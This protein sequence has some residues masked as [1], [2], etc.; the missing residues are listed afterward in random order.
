M[1][2]G[3]FFHAIMFDS[4][5][6]EILH[7]TPSRSNFAKGDVG[8]IVWSSLAWDG[9][10]VHLTTPVP[11]PMA[12]G[13]ESIRVVIVFLKKITMSVRFHGHICVMLHKIY[14]SEISS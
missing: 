1:N 3:E 9:E 5:H 4:D 14:A 7:A 6:F 8:V 13:P 12:V 11:E 2:R 10:F